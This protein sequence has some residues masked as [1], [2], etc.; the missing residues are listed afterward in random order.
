MGVFH[1]PHAPGE[2]PVEDD[3]EWPLRRVP[4]RL[5]DAPPTSRFSSGSAATS[6]CRLSI[7]RSVFFS[8]QDFR[9][10]ELRAF[11][12]PALARKV[13]S[14]SRL[15]VSNGGPAHR[16]VCRRSRSWADR[17]LSSLRPQPPF[18]KRGSDGLLLTRRLQD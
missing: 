2:R 17:P 10:R 3:I 11:P 14:A 8:T 13:R 15:E 1:A 12:Q 16:L 18:A 4:H 9:L 5:L 6:R 7:H